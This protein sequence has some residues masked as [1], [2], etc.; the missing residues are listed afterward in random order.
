ME[1]EQYPRYPEI[2]ARL[3]NVARRCGEPRLLNRLIPARVGA[4]EKIVDSALAPLLLPLL[5]R[6]CAGAVEAMGWRI[7][8][9][10]SDAEPLLKVL[11]HQDPVTQFLAAEA[12][13][14]GAD[15]GPE[16]L[17][18]EHRLRERPESPPTR[19]RGPGRTRRRAGPRHPAPACPAMR[20]TRCRS[21]AA[22]AI[23]H[24]G[25]SSKSEDIFKLLDRYAKAEQVVLAS[26][27]V[28]GLRWL[29]THA[30]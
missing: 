22:E 24:L 13:A 28:R 29:D 4:R 19:R 1:A 5:T 23:G 10:G 16:R 8:K 2:L 11:S 12:L 26:N 25:R 14:K 20:G 3:W 18:R 21:R 17:A 7:R 6:R 9:R 15:R 30:G 27:A